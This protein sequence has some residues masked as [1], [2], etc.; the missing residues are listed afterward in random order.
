MVQYTVRYSIEWFEGERQTE[1]YSTYDE[2]LIHFEDIR[3]YEGVFGAYIAPV[4]VTDLG[5]EE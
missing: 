1:P 5:T 3:G 4:E 2:A